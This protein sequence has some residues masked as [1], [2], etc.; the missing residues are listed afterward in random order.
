MESEGAVC[1]KVG[2]TEFKLPG[3]GAE[4]FGMISR[5][6]SL[7]EVV[8]KMREKYPEAA[9]E[10]IKK[11]Y[12]SLCGTLKEFGVI[13]GGGRSISED[14][15][16][17]RQDIRLSENQCEEWKRD[18]TQEAID[19]GKREGEGIKIE[20]RNG[21][22]GE[23]LM[24]ESGRRAF[25]KNVPFYLI[26]D[27]TYKCPFDCV[28]CYFKG[29]SKRGEMGVEK[30]IEILSIL[31]ELGVYKIDFT[32]GEVFNKRD[33]Q[34]LL[35]ESRKLGFYV[36]VLSNGFLLKP[37]DIDLLK[38]Y[39][40]LVKVTPYG[41]DEETCRS[42]TQYTGKGNIHKAV[43]EN[44]SKLYENGN[45]FLI[46]VTFLKENFHHSREFLNLFEH[47]GQEP[48]FS[49][50]LYS[51]VRGGKYPLRH[52]VV[53]EEIE[54]YKDILSILKGRETFEPICRGGRNLFAIRP[55][56]DVHPC[57]RLPVKI[58]N[59][60]DTNFKEVWKN[61]KVLK[62]I[63]ALKKED[64]NKCLNCELNLSC[65]FCIAKNLEET[66]SYKEPSHLACAGASI[67][68]ILTQD[69]KSQSRYK[70]KESFGRNEEN[71]DC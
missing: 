10:L 48:L 57:Y 14:Q 31:K 9:E 44:L 43:M 30:C 51:G 58:A 32:G 20:V 1:I 40:I 45:R 59:I 7:K 8:G 24:E 38:D 47:F 17:S 29:R 41:C 50:E 21:V 6:L 61:H 69:K 36:S 16:I 68:K 63:R 11:D 18:K 56:G 52:Q 5:G 12:V 55:N 13:E 22:G 37:Q 65:N 42:I 70:G 2:T 54:K 33:V 60:T 23:T 27:V 49:M 25:L 64:F 62:K 39:D 46:N 71:R 26:W 35:I 4:Y 34:R 28:H 15:N 3:T 19:K 53:K 67:H 66:G